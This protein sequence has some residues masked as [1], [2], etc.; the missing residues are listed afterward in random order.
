MFGKRPQQ[1]NQPPPE[2]PPPGYDMEAPMPPEPMSPYANLPPSITEQQLRFLDLPDEVP[3]HMQKRLWGLFSRH[4]ELSNIFNEGELTRAR[5]R[6][7]LICRPMMWENSTLREE[8]DITFLERMQIE[9]FVD[10]LLRKSYKQ[11]ERRLLAPWLQEVTSRAEN[12]ESNR[13]RPGG[14]I[15][16]GLSA[17]F[18]GRR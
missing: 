3:E 8:G 4:S 5:R 11:Q 10:L 1:Y 6:V 2:L 16:R 12:V 7:R 9:H 15:S 18:G 13:N 17:I 14:T